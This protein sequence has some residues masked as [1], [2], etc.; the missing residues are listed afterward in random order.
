MRFLA[1]LGTL[2]MGIIAVIIGSI[3]KDIIYG[4]LTNRVLTKKVKEST[5]PAGE[6]QHD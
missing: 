3:I 5:I 1:W 2:M 6:T 4:W